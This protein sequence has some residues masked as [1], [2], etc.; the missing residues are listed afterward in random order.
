MEIQL[1]GKAIGVRAFA[2]GLVINSSISC[3]SVCHHETKPSAVGWLGPASALQCWPR[4]P[5]P[6][7]ERPPS[8][9]NADRR[10]NPV[11]AEAPSAS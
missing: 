5:P 6:R 7:L 3:I 1:E 9:A 4:C 10:K 8:S 11:F 2:G